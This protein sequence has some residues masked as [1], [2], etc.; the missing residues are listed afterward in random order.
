MVIAGTDLGSGGSVRFGATVATA[1]SWSATSVTATVPTTLA[2]GAVDVTVTPSSGAAS[3]ALGFTVDAPPSG[4]DTMA[5]V[6]TAG[7]A[8]DNGWYNHTLKIRLTATDNAGG[9]GVASITYSVD[10]GAPVTV[11]GASATATIEVARGV[12]GDAD[13]DDDDAD[14]DDDDDVATVVSDGPHSVS[15]YATDIAGNRETAHTLTVNIDTGKPWTK[16]PRSVKVRRYQKVTLNY[17][18][19]DAASPTAARPRSSSS[20]RTAAARW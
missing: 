15:Y 4:D 5:P 16:A 13:S 18:V 6:T 9:S 19:G 10:G 3:N 2:P 17:A 8:T 14:G 20:S 7:G 11:A 1:T 12:K